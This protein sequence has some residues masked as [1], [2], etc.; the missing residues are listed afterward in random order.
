MRHR[1][2]IPA[3]AVLLCGSL[4]GDA[5]AGEEPL[6]PGDRVRV[7]APAVSPRRIEGIVSRIDAETLTI[8]STAD[9]ASREVPRSLIGTL[10]VARGT[11]SRWKGGAIAGAA[12]GVG[13]GL[14]ISNPPSSSTGTSVNGGGLAAGIVVGAAMGA[15]IGAMLKTDRW[16]PVPAGAIALRVQPAP[17]R[18]MGLALSVSF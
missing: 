3:A 10:E 18:G 11:R 8:V 17:G 4:A 1:L 16:M 7:T 2:L 13:L 15:G 12:W 6:K 9:T 5:R 14:L